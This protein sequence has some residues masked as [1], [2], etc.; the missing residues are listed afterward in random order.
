M[1]AISGTAFPGFAGEVKSLGNTC[2]ALIAPEAFNQAGNMEELLGLLGQAGIENG[3]AKREPS[4]YPVPKQKFQPAHWTYAVAHAALDAAGR[5]VNTELAERRNLILNNPVP[6]NHYPT[7]T[8]LVTAYQMVKAGEVARSHRHT[9]NALR[10]VLQSKPGMYTIVDGKKIPMVENDVLLTPNWSWHAHSNETNASAYWLDFLD[11]PLTHLLGPMF[12]EHHEDLIEKSD[13]ID[14]QSPCR[15]P[16]AETV[17]RLNAASELSPGRRE[18]QLGD[19]A[20]RTIA[21]HVIRLE[22][23]ASF[24]VSPST[25]SCVYA[26]MMG[27][28]AVDFGAQKF[29]FAR[30]DAIAA[31]SGTK[32]TW[33]A[34]DQCTL[35]RVS[36]EPLMRFLDWL[37]PIPAQ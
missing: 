29:A 4:M 35:L 24:E 12:F 37:R 15:F 2:M 30:G 6:G 34:T 8:T 21:L 25:L 18:I 27:K 3:W 1:D 19:P 23:G 36:D 28:G 16:F 33:T 20:M 10:L 22:A 5:F 32:Q 7:V 26:I 9:S 11:V 31:P 17:E 14:A 13:I